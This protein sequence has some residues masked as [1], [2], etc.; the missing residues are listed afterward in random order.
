SV[1]YSITPRPIYCADG[2]KHFDITSRPL[3][4]RP[5]IKK[6]L[7]DFP[8]FAFW[9]PGSGIESSRWIANSA[10]WIEEKHQPDLNLVYLP[11]LDYNTQKLGPDAPE[12][13]DD[14]KMI[15]DVV[16]DLLDYFAPRNVRVVLLSE[17]GITPVDRPIHLNRLFRERGWLQIKDE[18]GRDTL[19]AGDCKAIAI[20][21]HQIAHVYVLDPSIREEVQQLLASTEG[22]DQVMDRSM[23]M[24]EGLDHERAGDFVVVSDERSW[25]TYYFWEDDKRAPDYARTVDIHR[26]PGYDP[27]EL[28]IP[29][30]LG[31]KFK[32]A[33]TLFRRKALGQRALM[34]VI[35]LD[36]TLVKGSHGRKPEDRDD[37]PLLIGPLNLPDRSS[38]GAIEVYEQLLAA[39]E[40]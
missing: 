35:P 5:K 31:P 21:D 1:D 32:I 38:I 8:F 26:K 37:W 39:L 9:G 15:D 4:I 34:D 23:Q 20:A 11:H 10:K 28:F 2:A 27:V 40:L 7:G 17:Y 6:D 13:A 19:E 12:I 22:V 25:F 24:Y 30:G 16:G 14:L 3:D 33:F 36:A 18:L 29:D